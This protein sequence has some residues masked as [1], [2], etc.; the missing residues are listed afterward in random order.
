MSDAVGEHAGL[1]GPCS[2]DDE[3]RPVDVQDG[4]PLGRIQAGEQVLV[5]CDGHPAMLAAAAADS[6]P[7]PGYDRTVIRRGTLDDIPAAAALRQRAWPDAIITA[8]GMRHQLEA[9]SEIARMGYFA[10]EADGILAGCDQCRLGPLPGSARARVD[11][12][13]RRS[14]SAWTGH[15][16][17]TRRRCRRPPGRDRDHGHAGGLARHARG[18]GTCPASR[19]CGGRL[20]GRLCGRPSHRD[21]A[22]RARRVEILS[23]AELDDP[24]ALYEAYLEIGADVPLEPP[25]NVTYEQWLASWWNGPLVD[26]DASVVALVDGELAA[27]TMIR[28]DRPS[29]RAQNNLA[30]TRRPY[31]NRE[32]ATLVKSHSLSRAGAL[33]ATIAVTSNEERNAPMLAVNTRLGY[34]PF[35]RR[36]EWERTTDPV[37]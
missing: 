15:R 26:R 1:P 13:L 9:H 25:E 10:A 17:A 6:P 35:A 19:V 28:V 14:G 33:G 36:L 34:R 7:A 24:F 4:F 21:S 23:F 2:G 37:S 32:L 20:L 3:H 27:M 12:P 11:E 16:H 22:P 30:G 18:A 8:E 29:G 31:R 5:R